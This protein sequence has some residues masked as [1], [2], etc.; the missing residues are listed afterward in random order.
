M[1]A[2]KSKSSPTISTTGSRT[3]LR[4]PVDGVP[5]VRS[6]V[7]GYPEN[8]D[9]MLRLMSLSDK[10]IAVL[11]ELFGGQGTINVSLVV[12]GQPADRVRELHAG[13]GEIAGD[14]K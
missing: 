7:T 8:K 10:K 2:N 3:F 11:A 12:A 13:A 5:H 14:G 1:A 6:G 4:R 9:V